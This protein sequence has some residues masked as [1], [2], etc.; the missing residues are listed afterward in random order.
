MEIMKKVYFIMKTKRKRTF[1]LELRVL[2]SPSGAYAQKC[3]NSLQWVCKFVT[4]WKSL[5]SFLSAPLKYFY[6]CILVH[7]SA[8][9][10][11]QTVIQ[12]LGPVG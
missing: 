12:R 9:T 1:Y 6:S 3:Q 10:L 7:N 5:F 8:N 4:S 11:S 2:Y